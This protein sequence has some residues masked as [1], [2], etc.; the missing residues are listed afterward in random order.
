MSLVVKLGTNF[1][2]TVLLLSIICSLGCGDKEEI[3]F[4]V[5]LLDSDEL[6]LSDQHI[7]A[8]HKDTHQIELNEDGIQKWNSYM[9]YKTIPK[10]ADSLYSKD[11][12]LKIEGKE[13]YRGKFSSYASSESYTEV[14]ILDALVKLDENN[15]TIWIQYDRVWP[16]DSYEED[17]RNSHEIISFFE[18]QGLLK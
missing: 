8:Y 4:G 18:K 1:L 11:F 10:L 12:V 3:A 13:I 5:F 7:K 16:I 2:F 14:V 9:T 17:P 6:I 15:N